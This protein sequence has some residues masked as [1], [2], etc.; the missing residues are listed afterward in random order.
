M[1]MTSPEEDLT[2]RPPG[3]REPSPSSARRRL[4]TELRAA[5]ESAGLTLREGAAGIQRSPATLSRLENGVSIPRIADV[6]AL[7]DHYAEQNPTAGDSRTREHLIELA[8]IG[9]TEGW[10]AAYRDVISG[11]MTYDGIKRY[12]EFENDA[13]A[14]HTF[15]PDLVPGLL[16]TRRYTQALVA[17]FFPRHS[18]TQRRR[19]VEFRL[20]RQQV[21]RHNGGGLTFTAIIG[22]AALR[23][24]IAPPDVLREQI[25]FLLDITRDPT[26]S[27]TIQVAP[28]TMG[29]RPALGGPFLIME[30][31]DV[32]ELELVYIE[33][34]T[35]AQ[36]L[37]NPTDCQ[38]YRR[39][40]DELREH[41]LTEAD[42]RSL[43]RELIDESA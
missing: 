35:G 34:R 37:Q 11:D 4:G 39:E 26:A 27:V 15:E 30:F 32:D 25:R 9:Y 36:Y 10:F 2:P 22:E 12:V 1:R 40:F 38:S 5:R 43:L 14:I 31:A 6:R 20:A 13:S 7:L 24:R 23:R 8:K 21:L 3:P 18:T 16:Q 17:L 29:I 28:I 42:S 33:G 19:L 41:A